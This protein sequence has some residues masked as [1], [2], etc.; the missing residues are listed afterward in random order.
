[1][2]HILEVSG[3]DLLR[4]GSFAKTLP[5]LRAVGSSHHSAGLRVPQHHIVE[6]P[7]PIAAPR[8]SQPVSL[9][10]MA[11]AWGIC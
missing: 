3:C 9:C 8:T 4:A 6:A 5:L 1:M 7:M 10:S 11:P 2:P